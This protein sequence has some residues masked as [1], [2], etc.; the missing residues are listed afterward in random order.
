[1][2]AAFEA[3]YERA[4]RDYFRI[5]FRASMEAAWRV[6][7]AS[8]RADAMEQLQSMKRAEDALAAVEALEP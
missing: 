1:M 3:F 2:S 7:R 8:M 4:V 5:G 6:G